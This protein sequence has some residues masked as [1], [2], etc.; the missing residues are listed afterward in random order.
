M[1]TLS[2]TPARILSRAEER[3]KAWDQGHVVLMELQRW[4][5]RYVHCSR[6]SPRVLTARATTILYPVDRSAGE[7]FCRDSA[8][9][10][11]S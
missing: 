10:V 6:S 9:G 2:G 11:G 5:H 3:L 7:C 4:D 8:P 1:T